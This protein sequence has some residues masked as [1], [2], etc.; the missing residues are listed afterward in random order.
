MKLDFNRLRF[1]EEAS[2][3]LS[4]LKGKTGL[5]PNLLARIGF[6][7]SLEDHTRPQLVDGLPDGEKEIARP[8]LTGKWDPLFLALFI[9]RCHADGIDESEQWAYFE[10]HMNRGVLLLY[11][12]IKRFSD[13]TT[14]LP[15]AYRIPS[16]EESKV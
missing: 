11:K 15:K 8:T 1:R 12:K 6:C 13:L 4:S 10:A 5:T 9:E 7:M 2:R 3:N 16:I 14:L